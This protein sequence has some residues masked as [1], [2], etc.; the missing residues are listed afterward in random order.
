[1]CA[2]SWTPD[3]DLIRNRSW[4]I[5][6]ILKKI[7]QVKNFRLSRNRAF[8]ADLQPLLNTMQANL[9]ARPETSLT[10][11]SEGRKKPPLEKLKAARVKAAEAIGEKSKRDKLRSR[12]HTIPLLWLSKVTAIQSSW[13]AH[14]ASSLCAGREQSHSQKSLQS[15]CSR[16]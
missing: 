12:L 4:P 11:S 8:L 16:T 3:N 2:S 5:R 10:K 7:F 1:M 13:K 15:N 9:A 6:K 14:Q